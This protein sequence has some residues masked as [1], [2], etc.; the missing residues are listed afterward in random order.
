VDVQE[1]VGEV[2]AEA[3]PAPAG[4]GRR[5]LASL[6][7]LVTTEV[8]A[9]AFSIAAN[10]L[11]AFFPFTLLLLTLCRSWLHWQGAY[12]VIVQLLRANLPVGA[13]FVIRNL[14]I[15]VYARP[16]V[17]VVSVG[18]LVFTSSG[19]FLPLEVALNKVWGIARNRNFLANLA[20]S[21][22]LA[23]VSGSMAFCSVLIAAAAQA[24]IRFGISWLPWHRLTATLSRGLLESVSVP[25]LIGVYLV[26][27]YF[28]PNGPV[29]LRRVLPA[30]VLAGVL[31]EVAKFIYSLSLPAFRF[32]EV[33]GPFELSATLLLWAFVG[34]LILL[35]GAS[36]CAYGYGFSQEP[37]GRR[38]VRRSGVLGL[39]T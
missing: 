20:V 32:R 6:S 25:L 2:Q 27:Y 29:P 16:R 13:E 3:V 19:V 21:F 14:G 36:F 28:L 35:W 17:Q 5:F 24:A 30:A 22:V 10:A 12:D 38:T 31:T 37:H 7:Y 15:L 11:L 39:E 26:I 8:H 1:K 23:V 34:S 4:F 9:Y 33:Y 18:V